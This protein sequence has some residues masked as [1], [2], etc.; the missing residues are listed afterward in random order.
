MILC[1]HN[2]A[3]VCFEETHCPFCEMIEEKDGEIADMR[4]EIKSLESTIEKMEGSE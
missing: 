1:A 3:E 2:H 4:N